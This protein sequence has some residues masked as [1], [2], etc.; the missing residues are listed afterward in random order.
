MDNEIANNAPDGAIAIKDGSVFCDG[1]ECRPDIIYRTPDGK[2]TGIE[3]KTGDAGLTD[4]QASVFVEAGFDADN[5]PL[6]PIP[7]HATVSGRLLRTLNMEPGETL[8]EAGLTDGIT[9]TLK[10][11]SG[12][13]EGN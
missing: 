4:N 6:Y 12:L 8:S 5:N 11:K 13:N 2:I 9:I 7:P 3:V 10:R 1:V